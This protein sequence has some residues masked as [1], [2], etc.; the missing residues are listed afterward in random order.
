M[1]M[2]IHDDSERELSFSGA[3]EAEGISGLLLLSS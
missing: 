2:Y 1:V 3:I